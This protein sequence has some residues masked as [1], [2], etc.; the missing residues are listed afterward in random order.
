MSPM[1]LNLFLV[2]HYI[3]A[4]QIVILES[5]SKP[6]SLLA[7]LHLHHLCI[8]IADC[9]PFALHLACST[10]SVGWWHQ[11]PQVD[12]MKIDITQMHKLIGAN[13]VIEDALSFTRVRT[14]LL[15][16]VHYRVQDRYR[17]LR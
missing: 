3:R 15:Y 7:L 12:D 11:H 13:K 16:G 8:L 14:T 6:K 4:P 17:M 1:P 2:L 5:I 9:D 10:T